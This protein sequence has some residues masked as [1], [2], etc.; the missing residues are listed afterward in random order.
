MLRSSAVAAVIRAVGLAVVFLLHILLAR[1]AVDATSYGV[2]AWSQN[3]LFLLGSLFALGIPIMASRLA[4]VQVYRGDS[5]GLRRVSS[6]AH[7][8]VLAISLAGAGAGL[9]ILWSLPPELFSGLSREAISLAVLA[10]P[11]VSLTMLRQALARAA[12]RLF[13]AFV[14]T[15]VLRPLLT[16]LL[17]LGALLLL[18]RPLTALDMLAALTLSLLLVLLIQVLWGASRPLLVNPEAPGA[19]AGA[20]AAREAP[21]AAGQGDTAPGA[22]SQTDATP[23]AIGLLRQSMPVFAT[24]LADIVMTYGNTLLLGL[25]GGPLA[26]ASFF[27][28]DRLAQLAAIP[29]S[30]TSAVIQP[31]LASAHAQ[32]D[33][34]RLQRVVTQAAHVALWPSLF[35]GL[36][37]F[38][39]GPWLLELFGGDF[40]AALPVLGALLVAQVSGALFGPCHQVLVM[41][42]RQRQVMRLTLLAAVLHLLLVALLIPAM[43]ALGAALGSIASSLLLAIGCWWLVRR[44]YDLRTTVF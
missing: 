4:A 26:A 8:C 20:V 21:V 14:P 40:A 44:E 27:V 15:Q 24:R 29:G 12:S 16:G 30:V 19:D 1:L 32:G 37:L 25:I 6:T 31:W 2:F 23:G 28:A 18:Q 34:A 39:A 35:G 43:G 42:G 17:A 33:Q 38:L 36:A 41:S 10:A 13:S 5:A 11:V 7:G 3:L 22:A 9:L